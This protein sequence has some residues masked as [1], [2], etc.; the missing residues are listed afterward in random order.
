M[1]KLFF[2]FFVIVCFIHNAIAQT[3]I[4]NIFLKN[5]FNEQEY[6][7]EEHSFDDGKFYMAHNIIQK[8]KEFFTKAILFRESENGIIPMGYFNEETFYNKNEVFWKFRAPAKFYAWKVRYSSNS[9]ILIFCINLGDHG[10]DEVILYWENGLFVEHTI[11][12]SLL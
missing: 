6:V 3:D 12:S 10:A 9:I 1:S 8:D 4:T 11:D 2:V 5:F 7:L